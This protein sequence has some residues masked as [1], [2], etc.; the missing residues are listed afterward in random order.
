M[1]V[2]NF[3]MLF[4]P[5]M[6]PDVFIIFLGTCFNVS[7]AEWQPEVTRFFESWR[8]MRFFFVILDLLLLWFHWSCGFL[9]E[10]IEY[11]SV[12]VDYYLGD[13]KKILKHFCC[14]NFFYD[15][16]IGSRL[17]KFVW[18]W[19][20]ETGLDNFLLELEDWIRAG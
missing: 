1:G 5:K 2:S 10:L 17:A 4:H 13:L 6:L 12:F 9:L 16:T 19:K 18:S 7:A 11:N 14:T 3:L 15:W 8:K 20:I